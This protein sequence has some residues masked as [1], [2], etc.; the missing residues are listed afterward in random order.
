MTSLSVLYIVCK[1]DLMLR[2]KQKAE[3][4]SL[5][6]I[7]P[8][9]LTRVY[10]HNKLSYG[11]WI[12]TDTIFCCTFTCTV[13][14]FLSWF[15]YCC[16]ILYDYWTYVTN[17]CLNVYPDSYSS[18]WGKLFTHGSSRLTNLQQYNHGAIFKVYW[19]FNTEVAHNGSKIY[20][21]QKNSVLLTT[22]A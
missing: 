2:W 22:R 8:H 16:Y 11:G 20:E 18:I 12:W 3:I 1:M 21:G 7:A 13:I 9:F 17:K 19:G 4:Q 15:H 6:S 10:L 5:V 14:I